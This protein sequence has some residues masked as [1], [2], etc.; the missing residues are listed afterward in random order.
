MVRKLSYYTVALVTLIACYLTPSGRIPGRILPG[1]RCCR[2][3]GADTG[4]QGSDWRLMATQIETRLHLAKVY[5]QIEAYAEA[6]DEYHQV[7]ALMEAERVSGNE[8]TNQNSD[9]AAA[10]YGLG[11]AYTG[12]EKV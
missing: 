4:L 10:Y 5:L 2:H 6:V 7:V 11:L 3:H 9:S 12:L 1:N 8:L